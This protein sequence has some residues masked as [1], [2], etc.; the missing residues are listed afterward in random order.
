MTLNRISCTDFPQEKAQ[1]E[2]TGRANPSPAPKVE[3]T[4]SGSRQDG[5][6]SECYASF[7]DHGTTATVGAFGQLLQFSD[8]L[9][10]KNSGVFCADHDGT[11]EPY[12]VQ[13]RADQL[14]ERL[15]DP[16]NFGPAPPSDPPYGLRFPGLI[17]NSSVQPHLEWTNWRWPCHQY[18]LR[19]FKDH[20]NLKLTIQWMVHEKTVLQRC[21]VQNNGEDFQ[22][23]VEFSKSMKIR[24]LDHLE[25]FNRFND[26][27]HNEVRP[28][29]RGYSWVCFQRF[30][31]RSV[32]SENATPYGVS[33]TCAVAINGET[34]TFENEVTPQKW[35]FLCQGRRPGATNE[36]SHTVEVITAYKMTL[37]QTPKGAWET[38]IIPWNTMKVIQS[39]LDKS[40]D[41]SLPARFS[42]SSWYH[43]AYMGQAVGT[44]LRGASNR[45]PEDTKLSTEMFNK[46]GTAGNQ[47]GRFTSKVPFN[48]LEEASPPKT[49]GSPLD[50]LVFAV[51]RNLEHILS[52]CAVQTFPTGHH[53]AFNSLP[54]ALKSVEATALTCGD[55]SGHRICW[56]ASL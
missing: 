56:S 28:G 51:R 6:N 11:D 39:V 26:E 44:Y 15:R 19:S 20:P 18:A 7:G 22:L 1:P 23:D 49:L 3:G 10:A 29:P 36:S 9:G 21:L 14:H 24:D 30:Q 8:Y 17:L 53:S 54:K 55:M 37:L 40:P 38:H 27:I 45:I 5:P 46:I 48:T 16:F 35:S 25:P 50:N 52:V 33:I 47:T 4:D 34:Q 12:F 42:G 31:G 13:R 43:I 32:A 2:D 41:Q